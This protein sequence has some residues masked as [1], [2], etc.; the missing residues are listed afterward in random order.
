MKK[1]GIFLDSWQYV[2]K[3]CEQTFYV[4]RNVVCLYQMCWT[5][6]ERTTCVLI[7]LFSNE[8]ITDKIGELAILFKKYMIYSCLKKMKTD[9]F[10]NTNFC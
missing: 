8:T 5:L 9:P 7:I 1:F 3:W 10:W 4:C 2:Q 6:T